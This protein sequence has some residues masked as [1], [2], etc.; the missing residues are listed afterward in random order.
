MTQASKAPLPCLI[1]IPQDRVLEVQEFL[2]SRQIPFNPQESML[3]L[4]QGHPERAALHGEQL[5]EVITE[6]NGYLEGDRGIKL[7]IPAKEWTLEQQRR[8]LELAITEFSWDEHLK[9]RY[10][11]FD[12]DP[13]QWAQTLDLYPDLFA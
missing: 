12:S 1:N 13:S 9:I 2:E 7:T 11:S 5:E 3:V 6:I 4:N 10:D 8:I